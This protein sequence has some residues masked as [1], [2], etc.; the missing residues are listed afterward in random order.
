MT[1][2]IAPSTE[3]SIAEPVVQALDARTAQI[4]FDTPPVYKGL[5]GELLVRFTSDPVYVFSFPSF[6]SFGHTSFLS[7]LLSAYVW[8]LRG[9]VVVWVCYWV[10]MVCKV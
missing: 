6:W 10:W 2:L 4:S 7:M 1:L 9:G 8:D 3:N 5:P